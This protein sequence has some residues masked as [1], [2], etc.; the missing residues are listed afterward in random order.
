MAVPTYVHTL[1]SP[2]GN[3]PPTVTLL[4]ATCY[5]PIMWIGDVPFLHLGS[6][7]LCVSS[8]APNEFRV[9]VDRLLPHVRLV[10]SFCVC[11]GQ[12]NS[13]RERPRWWM[14]FLKLI[15]GVKYYGI[16]TGIRCFPLWVCP[17]R[18]RLGVGACERPPDGM[19]AP[20][21]RT[22]S[23]PGVRAGVRQAV[24]ACCRLHANAAKRR[25]QNAG[26]HVR[27]G[28]VA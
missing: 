23:R 26:G 7:F 14:R 8:I 21:V 16:G 24:R 25:R 1:L 4:L 27:N 3:L 17:Q 6:V 19:H 12:C 11:G 18:V 5:V 28:D 2:T 13:P 22:C 15:S 9:D 20:H 10:L